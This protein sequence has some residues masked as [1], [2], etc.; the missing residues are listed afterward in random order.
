MVLFPSSTVGKCLVDASK[1]ER[2]FVSE[3]AHTGN[4]SFA[5][6]GNRKMGWW[7]GGGEGCQERGIYFVCF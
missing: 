7:L 1:R 6:T 5:V 4:L 3:E 2:R